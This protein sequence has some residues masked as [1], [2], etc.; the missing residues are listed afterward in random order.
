MKI[1]IKHIIVEIKIK[2]NNSSLSNLWF[3]TP[4]HQTSLF[5]FNFLGNYLFDFV[6]S[7]YFLVR[8]TWFCLRLYFFS[9]LLS[10][11][12]GFHHFHEIIFT[13]AFA[14]NICS[15]FAWVSWS[16]LFLLFYLDLAYLFLNLHFF[17]LL[18]IK[19]FHKL[20][21]V[22][23]IFI[24]INLKFSFRLFLFLFNRLFFRLNPL[25]IYI[26][27]IFYSRL[28][29]FL[30]FWFNSLQLFLFF[31]LFSLWL[32]LLL[33]FLFFLLRNFWIFVIF[34]FVLGFHSIE[35]FFVMGIWREYLNS[36]WLF[37][38]HRLRLLW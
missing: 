32:F 15:F 9:L 34:S 26:R 16:V 29:L 11:A 23:L 31:A 6:L 21:R 35:I 5:C 19:I 18:I 12:F 1:N 22:I 37:Y 10:F 20:L 4:T 7:L 33:L 38:N 17:W 3:T 28:N 2:I 30:S 13:V 36:A 25:S 8:K 14:L 24:R 27:L